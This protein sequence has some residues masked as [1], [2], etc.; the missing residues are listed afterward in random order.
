MLLV[1]ATG[2]FHIGMR[3]R[4]KKLFTLENVKRC[5]ERLNFLP[6]DVFIFCGDLSMSKKYDENVKEALSFLSSANARYRFMVIGNHDWWYAPKLRKMLS[7]PSYIKILDGEGF[8]IEDLEVGVAGT[9]GWYDYSFNPEACSDREKYEW[10]V[11]VTE[12]ELRKLESGLKSIE[13]AKVKLV[14][15]HFS[16]TTETVKGDPLIETCGSAKFMEL[17]EA[18]DV[19]YVFHGH[20]HR[21]RDD[22]LEAT[23]RKTMIFNVACDKRGFSPLLVKL[24][25][26][27]VLW[28]TLGGQ[29][30]KE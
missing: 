25:D 11:R 8:Y 23:V 27:V 5:I 2:D 18:Y 28:S 24:E 17:L 22:N 16:P 29:D 14:A 6:V 26:R 19:D 7:D 13:D 10:A 20:S 9:R 4:F 3:G 21:C 15:M 12:R 30:E 1:A